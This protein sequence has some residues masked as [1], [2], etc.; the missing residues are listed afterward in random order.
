MGMEKT[1]NEQQSWSGATARRIPEESLAALVRIVDL[2]RSGRAH[3]R[4]EIGERTGLSR[5]IVAQRVSELLASGLVREA[6][7]AST[8]G[9]PPRTLELR[10]DAG[11]LAVAD[12][13][14]SSIDVAITDVGGRVLAHVGEP[15]SITDGPVPILSRIDE[16]FSRLLADATHPGPLWGI[17]LGVPGPVEFRT[18]RPISPPIMP[19]WDRYPVRMHFMDRYGVPAWVDNDV[20]VMALGESRHG[21]ARGHANVIL[22]KVGTGIGSGIISDGVMHR[23]AQGAAGDIGHI[24][25]VGD[26]DVV[27][28]CGKIG[29][30]EALAGGAAIARDGEVLARTGR[31]RRLADRLAEEGV[32][33]AEDVA[34]AAAMGDGAALEIL[35]RSGRLVG[36]TLAA[37]VNFFN[38][39]LIVI[40][41]GVARASDEYLAAIREVIYAR[42]LPLATR[43]LAIHP[44]SLGGLAG[45]KGA[46][47]MVLDQIFSE[48]LL[49]R[50]IHAGRPTELELDAA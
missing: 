8:G 32:L 22:V 15:A 6:V 2:I 38:P 9:R 25:V 18:G 11:H 41:G 50:W 34:H 30:L 31:S 3:S 40:G 7:A 35:L 17:G 48:E 19:G 23:G 39:S 21:I 37:L 49:G 16:L 27:C 24:R 36:E 42:S 29:C 33:T 12:I 46:A 45:V 1:T 43:S 28:R 44:S 13:G 10:A 26:T 20:N 14:A 47:A 4:S 5:S